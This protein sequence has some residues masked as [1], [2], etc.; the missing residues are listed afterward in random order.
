MFALFCT[1]L[2]AQNDVKKTLAELNDI[3]QPKEIKSDSRL[4]KL[5]TVAKLHGTANA[6]NLVPKSAKTEVNDKVSIMVIL[7]DKDSSGIK[8]IDTEYLKQLG[9]E[10]LEVHKKEALCLVEISKVLD[11]AKVLKNGYIV[12]TPP[13]ILTDVIPPE[14]PALTNSLSYK[15]GGKGGLGVTIAI[16][17]NGY[18]GLVT[19]I[20]GGFCK[21]PSYMYKNNVS[22]SSTSTFETGDDTSHGRLVYETIYAHA[23]DASYELYNLNGSSTIN[24]SLNKID[25]RNVDIISMSLGGF[26]NY[27]NKSESFE[28][29]IPTDAMMF[30]ASG[31][32]AKGHIQK[33]TST[34]EGDF[35]LWDATDLYNRFTLP[36]GQTIKIALTWSPLTGVNSSYDQGYSTADLDLYL[37]KINNNTG[38]RNQISSSS[39]Q[40]G[41]EFIEYTNNSGSNEILEYAIKVYDGALY[42]NFPYVY[43]G[44]VEVF[45]YQASSSGSGGFP[46]EHQNAYSSL[47]TFSNSTNQKVLIIGAV[48]KADYGSPNATTGIIT[49][50]SSQGPNNTGYYGIDFVGP[51]ETGVSTGLT[52]TFGGTSCATPNVAGTVATFWSA[53]P[54]YSITGILD[55]LYAKSDVYKDWG[56]ANLDFIYGHGGISL[57]NYIPNSKYMYRYSNNN[58]PANT[59]YNF[60]TF[61]PYYNMTQAQYDMTTGGTVL[62]LDGTTRGAGSSSLFGTTA[63]QGLNKRILYKAITPTSAGFGY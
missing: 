36:V 52:Q 10:V 31:N 41:Y 19:A 59:P 34:P 7:T 30:I 27:W 56:S 44:E 57:Y 18:S 61:L 17:D 38:V 8:L 4:Y 11:I 28:D 26:G 25:T 43:S 5:G 63:T 3:K 1:Q 54:Y 20:S 24:G 14:G 58:D 49:D 33:S 2:L 45:A 51:T 60:S 40:T 12:V 62:I 22:V 29:A 15:N 6:L 53:H 47:G 16:I 48:D 23:P 50:Y 21:A 13:E 32:Y 42:L 35:M 39:S 46:T 37:Y 9:L 55:I